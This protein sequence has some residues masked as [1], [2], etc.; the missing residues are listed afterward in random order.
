VN[1]LSRYYEIHGRVRGSD[2]PLLL[3]HGGGSTIEST[4]GRILPEL[5][6][7]RRALAVELQAHGHTKEIN[8]C[9]AFDQDA[10]DVAALL[11]Q[12]INQV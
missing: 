12:L 5:A 1:G 9:L 6:Q 3:I 7:T 8:R 4:F 2:H 11:G 10:D